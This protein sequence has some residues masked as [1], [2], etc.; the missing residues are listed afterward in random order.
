MRIFPNCVAPIILGASLMLLVGPTLADPVPTTLTH[1]GRLFD[2]SGAPVTG[3]FPVQI[4]IYANINDATS[5]WGEAIDVEFDDGYYSIELGKVTPF[6]TALDGSLRYLGIAVGNDAEMVPR[7]EIRSVPYALLAGDVRGDIHPSGVYIDSTPVIDATG[8]WVG[9]PT[10]LQG[11]QGQTGPQGP[12]GPVGPVGPQGITGAAG[13]QGSMGP[14]GPAGPQGPI[15]PTG[16]LS[17]GSAAGNT[18]YWNGSSWIVGTSNI[19]NNGGNVG[20]GTSNPFVKLQVAGDFRAD[21]SL[22]SAQAK[23]KRDFFTF[24]TTV[25]GSTPIHVKTNIPIHSN[26]MYRFLVEGYDYGTGTAVNSETVGYPYTGVACL[27]NNSVSDHVAG[28]VTLSQYCSFDGFV[29][30]RL[31]TPNTYYLGFSVSGWFVNPTGTSFDVSATG[32]Q[33]PGNL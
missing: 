2:A 7:S 20:I 8:K 22:S 11:P 10:G 23:V 33:Q 1:Q 15:G 17:G 28:G 27:T 19:F 26:V 5:L 12:P 4:S 31:D 29:V 13:P 18:P 16:L 6:G 25:S 30:L 14:Q 3:K 9:D 21:G 24:S 32:V